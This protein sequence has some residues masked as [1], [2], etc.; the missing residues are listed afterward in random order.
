MAQR[1]KLAKTNP[2]VPDL[3]RSIV[4]IKGDSKI[5]TVN[6]HMF[7]P[8]CYLTDGSRNASIRYGMPLLIR[9]ITKQNYY[10]LRACVLQT[11]SKHRDYVSN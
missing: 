7:N 6:I 1:V 8:C 11:W 5:N 4:S 3:R 2:V 9:I 10:I